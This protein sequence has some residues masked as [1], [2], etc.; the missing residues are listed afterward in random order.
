MTCKKYDRVGVENFK[1][2]VI[3]ERPIFA[4]RELSNDSNK[5]IYKTGL[6]LMI[7]QGIKILQ[8]FF[9]KFKNLTHNFKKRTVNIKSLIS[10]KLKSKQKSKATSN[11]HLMA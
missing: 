4:F 1:R 5:L 9:R 3:Y 10:L 11:L 2:D 7:C 6:I 8:I